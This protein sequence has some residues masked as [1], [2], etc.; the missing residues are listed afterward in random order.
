MDNGISAFP[1]G[2]IRVSDAE[3]D[4]AVAELSK[5]FQAGRLTQEEF[6]DRS[7][8]ALQARTGAELRALFTDLPQD[9]YPDAPSAGHTSAP[10][11]GYARRP[12]RM[13][14]ARVVIVCFIAAI[15]AGNVVSAAGHGQFGWLIPVAILLFVFTRV[16]R[17]W[18]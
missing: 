6:E 17:R 4:Q 11:P 5:H 2:D 8:G 12:V 7:G 1:R 16:G 13:P 14:V 18:R 10:V 3:R 9:T 15:I